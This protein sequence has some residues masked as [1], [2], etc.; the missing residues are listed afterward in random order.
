MFAK[1]LRDFIP[2]SDEFIK[3]AQVCNPVAIGE[4]GAVYAAWKK[5]ENR[6]MRKSQKLEFL[7]ALLNAMMSSI[8]VFSDKMRNE[9]QAELQSVNEQI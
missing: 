8:L 4:D 9:H 2:R 6:K 7:T 3:P 5:P 1:A